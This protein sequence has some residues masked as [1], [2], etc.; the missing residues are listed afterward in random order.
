MVG[1]IIKIMK[2]EPQ[3]F[4]LDQNNYFENK[5]VQ[6]PTKIIYPQKSH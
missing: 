4:L 6:N 1:H 5:K 2:I 3:Y